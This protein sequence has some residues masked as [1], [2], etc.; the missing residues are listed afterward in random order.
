MAPASTRDA[1]GR[2]GRMVERGLRIRHVGLRRDRLRIVERGKKALDLANDPCD[3][4]GCTP[5][6][7]V[8]RSGNGADGDEEGENNDGELTHE[9]VLLS[10]L[11][12]K[13][14]IR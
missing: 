5:I 3:Q 1:A 14:R 7:G 4:A 13:S 6:A 10:K 2:G 12:A 9:G 11:L 8:I